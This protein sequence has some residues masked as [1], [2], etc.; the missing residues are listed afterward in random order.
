MLERVFV[1]SAFG[2]LDT[3]VELARKYCK[4]ALVNG[5]A[6][7]APHLIY[8]QML[9][10]APDER[11]LGIEAGLS[12][13]SV[14]ERM[15]VFVVDGVISD[16]MKTEIDFAASRE[17]PIEWF[18]VRPGEQTEVHS[19]PHLSFNYSPTHADLLLPVVYVRE[20]TTTFEYVATQLRGG[21]SYEAMVS[22]LDLVLNTQLE[23]R[24]ERVE[25]EWLLSLHEGDDEY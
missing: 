10:E 16:G 15:W 9:T 8:P 7:I 20:V 13:L 3:N 5:V 25:A 19:L 1:C 11:A 14:C 21:A 22:K 24:D 12:Y 18:A 23:A 17:T 2:G 4:F 6:P